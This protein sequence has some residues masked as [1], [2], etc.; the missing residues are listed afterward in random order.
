MQ[1]PVVSGKDTAKAL[2]RL[3]YELQRKRGKGSHM[4]LWSEAKRRLIIVP[5]HKELDRGTL[6]AIL[7]QAEIT[8]DQFVEALN[9]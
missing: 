8:V 3:G 2:G 6:R 1:L 5:D 7:R 9:A 4:A